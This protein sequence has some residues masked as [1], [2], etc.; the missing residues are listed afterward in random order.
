MTQHVRIMPLELV[1]EDAMPGYAGALP[2]TRHPQLANRFHFWRGAS[3]R[4]YACTLFPVNTA[5]CYDDAISLFV[6]R[7]R[8]G[9]VL[10]SVGASIDASSA[11]PDVDEIHV[12]LVQGGA[13][14]LAFVL[15]DLTALVALD[16]SLDD[17]Q[18]RAA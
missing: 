3:S 9:P 7:G 18:L 14:A 1:A 5:P 15:R 17:V 11:P 10:V 6:R 4:R 13:D 2:T 16:D 8:S 12:H